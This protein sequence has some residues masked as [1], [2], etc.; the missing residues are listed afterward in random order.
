MP[1]DNASP[2][3]GVIDLTTGVDFTDL[4]ST[5]NIQVVS[6]DDGDGIDV[7]VYGRNGSGTVVSEVV[8]VT[9]QTPVPTSTVTAWER[10][11]KVLKFDTAAG[12]IAVEQVIPTKLGTL[13]GGSDDQ[14]ILD[15]GASSISGSYAGLVFRIVSGLG[16]GIIGKV[17]GYNGSTKILT[18]DKVVVVDETSEYQLAPGVVLFKSPHEILTVRRP[19]YNVAAA[20]PSGSDR[21]FFEKFFWRNNAS[22]TLLLASVQEV[23]NPTNKI[24]FGL[25]IG[26]TS[27]VV[28]RLTAPVV[29]EMIFGRL[30]QAVP[31]IPPNLAPAQAV[32]V[33]LSFAVPAGQ[34]PIRSSY[35]S[36]LTGQTA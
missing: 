36:A 6:S 19:F 5:G 13:Q 1:E 24:T 8:Q 21:V 34:S 35:Q 30:P 15:S 7:Q 31:S 23:S 32:G 27:S 9:G 17:V 28:T 2:T 16:A 26:V 14:V 3:G 4:T 25:D 10:I 29:P 22:E 18:L 12:D 20:A 33:W 11:M